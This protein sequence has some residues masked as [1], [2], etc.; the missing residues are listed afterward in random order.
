MNNNKIA[1]SIIVPVYNAEPYLERCIN[2]L[3][4]QT[5]KKIEIIL[6]DDGSTDGSLNICRQYEK[7][8]ARITVIHQENTGQNAARMKGLSYSQGECI[9][10][11]DSD[12]WVESNM[13]ECLLKLYE[14]YECDLVTSG[15][16]VDYLNGKKSSTRY[17][18]LEQGLYLDLEKD[19]FPVMLYDFKK[20]RA[21]IDGHLVNKLFKAEKIKE[22]FAKI[23][24]RMIVAEDSFVLYMYCLLC[25]S[26]YI[27]KECFYHYDMKPGTTSNTSDD[28]LLNNTYIVYQNFMKIFSKYKKPYVLIRQLK[29]FILYLESRNLE[30]LYSINL[31][32]QGQWRFGFSEEV[33]D[34]K[35]VIYGAGI[36]GQALYHQFIASGKEQNIVAWVDKEGS[37]KSDECLYPIE[38]PQVLETKEFDYLL[39]AVVDEKLADNIAMKLVGE[40]G[41]NREKN[42]MESC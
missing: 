40:Y 42:N 35:I 6:V 7:E 24:T 37:K 29:P 21:A 23:D 8:D 20:Q 11:I 5:Y 4:N 10:F 1:V 34:F 3:I 12:D 15:M 41:I 26:M 31:N 28:R 2:S 39:I 18:L 17:D 27:S 38:Y 25:N 32:A 9:S 22:V 19:V 13:Y 36:C 14:E 30:L 33:Y 16:Y